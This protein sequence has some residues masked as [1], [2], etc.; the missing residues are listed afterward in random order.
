MVSKYL[1]LLSLMIDNAK[2]SFHE[3]AQSKDGYLK[4]AFVGLSFSLVVIMVATV[5]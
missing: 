2:Q 4:I 1:A 5:V 3:T